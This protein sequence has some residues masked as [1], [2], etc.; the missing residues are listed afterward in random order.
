MTFMMLNSFCWKAKAYG[1]DVQKSIEDS[2]ENPDT[3]QD[4]VM[5]KHRIWRSDESSKAARS[6]A[7]KSGSA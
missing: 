3:P 1:P 4:N 2:A 7:G 5:H 6:K